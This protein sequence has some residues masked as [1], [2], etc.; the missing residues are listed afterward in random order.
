MRKALVVFALQTATFCCLPGYAEVNTFD[1]DP[2]IRRQ[3]GGKGKHKFMAAE[4]DLAQSRGKDFFLSFK[5]HTVRISHYSTIVMALVD[6]N[7]ER[8][9]F[10]LTRH[11]SA[12]SLGKERGKPTGRL[13][14]GVP[15]TVVFSYKAADKSVR[16]KLKTEDGRILID[17]T[18]AVAGE[19]SL[20]TFAVK[21]S[22]PAAVVWYDPLAR[23]I[24]VCS[25][26][27]TYTSVVTVDDLYYNFGE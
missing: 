25:G 17:S 15:Y 24:Y 7:G 2:G 12:F 6:A 3:E 10:H 13:T 19:F 4:F 26:S 23:N 20:E 18:F 16:C 27:G 11:N 1:L 5:M 22:Q 14:T 21:A 8:L 9:A